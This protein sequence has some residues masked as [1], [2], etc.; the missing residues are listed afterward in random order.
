VEWASFK[1]SHALQVCSRSFI[2]GDKSRVTVSVRV[3]YVGFSMSA[4]TS[5]LTMKRHIG[6]DRITAPR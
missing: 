1:L 3:I 4:P 5:A 6:L 2:G